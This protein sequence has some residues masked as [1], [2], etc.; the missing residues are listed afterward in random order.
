MHKNNNTGPSSPNAVT[1]EFG[2]LAGVLLLGPEAFQKEMLASIEPLGVALLGRFEQPAAVNA[3]SLPLPTE[4]VALLIATAKALLGLLRQRRRRLPPQV[5]IMVVAPLEELS[6]VLYHM[7][8]EELLAALAAWVEPDKV[9]ER[10]GNLLRLTGH[11]YA[12]VP[13]AAM[14]LLL[15][16]QRAGAR[17]AQLDTQERELLELIMTGAS[18]AEIAAS[19]KLPLGRVRNR[20]RA[21]LAKLGCR[22]RTAAAILAHR[23]F[24]QDQ[25][26][27]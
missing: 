24:H 13:E 19:L 6:T 14:G 15:D 25:W 17:L 16:Q 1:A 23:Y 10:I 11:N 27:E 12:A 7:E 18:N 20:V 3:A 9:A 26:E 8:K 21:L 2:D 5:R 22:S 4:K